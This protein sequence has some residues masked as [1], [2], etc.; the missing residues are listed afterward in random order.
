MKE[1][2]V[3]KIAYDMVSESGLINLSRSE[4]CKRANIADG[5][6]SYIMGCTFSDFTKT[7]K[8]IPTKANH[9]VIKTR[10]NKSLRKEQ[11]LNIAIELG[12]DNLN[13]CK[14]AEN[15]G[16]SVSLVNHYWGS[17]KQ[18]QRAVRRCSK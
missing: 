10:T 4:L 2:R 6:F 15:A 14:I 13:I 17:L 12:Y 18:L 3:R 11:I 8:R 9:K 1:I 5:S 16:V 7:L